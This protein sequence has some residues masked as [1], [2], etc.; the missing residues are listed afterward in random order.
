MVR[1]RLKEVI[2]RQ[3]S[4]PGSSALSDA[5]EGRYKD[6]GKDEMVAEYDSGQSDVG[7]LQPAHTHC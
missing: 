6:G 4:G 2:V 7:N 3:R 1:E 5:S